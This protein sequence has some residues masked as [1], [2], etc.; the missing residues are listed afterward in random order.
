MQNGECE[1]RGDKWYRSV[2]NLFIVKDSIHHT[3]TQI[4][5]CNELLDWGAAYYFNSSPS[6]NSFDMY[7]GVKKMYHRAIGLKWEGRSS[8]MSNE[9]NVENVNKHFVS[10]HCQ[11]FPYFF[12]CTELNFLII[13][14]HSNSKWMNA[15]CMVFPFPF[16][17]LYIPNRVSP[18]L[19]TFFVCWFVSL[20]FICAFDTSCRGSSSMN[21]SAPVCLCIHISSPRNKKKWE[22]I[23]HHANEVFIWKLC[24]HTRTRTQT[25]A[26]AIPIH[27]RCQLGCFKRRFFRSSFPCCCCVIGIVF[28]SFIRT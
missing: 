20:V 11:F 25:D 14:K 23:G 28:W 22:F 18:R 9:L 27:F 15:E 16:L 17:M 12:F 21:V 19:C 4:Y 6:P 8:K 10:Q 13:S 1:T 24:I 26:E 7:S 3:H 2:Y 5:R